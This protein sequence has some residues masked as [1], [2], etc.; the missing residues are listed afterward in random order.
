MSGS[1][2]VKNNISEMYS[3]MVKMLMEVSKMMDDVTTKYR[4]VVS[5]AEELYGLCKR[6]NVIPMFA[7]EGEHEMC[8]WAKYIIESSRV[9]ESLF[10]CVMKMVGDLY[11]VTEILKEL[12]KE[13]TNKK[14]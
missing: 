1:I 10:P 9:T 6:Y 8:A 14:K 2:D 13:M 3:N 7:I 4:K 11:S 12:A 5:M